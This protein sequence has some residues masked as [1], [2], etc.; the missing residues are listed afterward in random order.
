MAFESQMELIRRRQPVWPTCGVKPPHGTAKCPAGSWKADTLHRYILS[1]E[2]CFQ[3]STSVLPA[4]P[5]CL[6]SNRL[7]LQAEMQKSGEDLVRWQEE[8][9]GIF[10]GLNFTWV[11]EAPVPDSPVQHSHGGLVL[12]GCLTGILAALIISLFI[13][14]I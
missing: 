4:Q 5:L 2:S 8:S 9:R 6:A 12:A 10:P 11:Q 13:Y 7:E 3:Q 1:L 14:K